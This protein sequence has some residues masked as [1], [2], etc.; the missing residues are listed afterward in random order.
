MCLTDWQRSLSSLQSVR[1][2]HLGEDCWSFN[3]CKRVKN[4]G[5]LNI[6]ICKIPLWFRRIHKHLKKKKKC[7]MLQQHFPLEY[8]R[9]YIAIITMQPHWDPSRKGGVI[10]K[11]LHL[12]KITFQKIKLST[13]PLLFSR[14]QSWTWIPC[15]F[16]TGLRGETRK[17]A[18]CGSLH[19]KRDGETLRACFHWNVPMILQSPFTGVFH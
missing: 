4:S 15:G 12:V 8:M 5:Y 19:L 17:A 10:W 14:G 1:H 9:V 11:L 6:P 16:S 18:E 3:Y 13:R 7:Q 2:T